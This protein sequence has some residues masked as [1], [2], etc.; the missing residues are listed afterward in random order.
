MNYTKEDILLLHR[1]YAVND[2]VFDLVYTHS[3]I[4]LEIAL[5]L[6]ERSNLKVDKDLVT[7]GAMVHDI[8]VYKVTDRTGETLVG[9]SYI[10]HSIEGEAILK[11]EGFSESIWRFA[12]HHT[13]VGIS[14]LDIMANNLRLPP[15]D[16]IAETTEEELIMYADKFHSKTTPPYFNSYQWFK[17]DISKF[18]QDKVTKFDELVNK[19]GLPDLENLS[20]KYSFAIR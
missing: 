16:Y 7:I 6:I 12:S 18:G 10:T 5:Q 8:G 2:F 14:K 11:K 9:M 17:N 20:N 13:G 4:V 3:Q 15:A 19:F 1:R